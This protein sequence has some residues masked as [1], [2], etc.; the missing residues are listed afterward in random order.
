MKRKT[1]KCVDLPSIRVGWRGKSYKGLPFY[2][3]RSGRYLTGTGC[4]TRE[5]AEALCVK[6]LEEEAR[7]PC[8]LCEEDGVLRELGCRFCELCLSDM[9]EICNVCAICHFCLRHAGHAETCQKA[10]KQQKKSS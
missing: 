3:A 5:E 9:I 4:A 8:D 10:A 7:V 6:M 2:V 1:N